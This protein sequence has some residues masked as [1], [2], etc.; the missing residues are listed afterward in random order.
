MQNPINSSTTRPKGIFTIQFFDN[1]TNTV[2]E[3]W[4][5]TVANLPSEGVITGSVIELINPSPCP[6]AINR[7]ANFK[8]S[9]TLANAL[10]L[11]SSIWIDTSADK[12]VFD[13]S[14]I[15]TLGCEIT[16]LPS[17]NS[18]VYPKCSIYELSDTVTRDFLKIDDFGAI[19]PGTRVS[20]M[21]RMMNKALPSDDTN[22]IVVHTCADNKGNSQGSKPECTYRVDQLSDAATFVITDTSCRA[23]IP[24]T[25]PPAYPSVSLSS[26]IAQASTNVSFLFVPWTA[27]NAS[28]STEL[29]QSS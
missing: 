22:T 27:I 29:P 23:T 26:Q 12:W 14:K 3:E 5:T 28:S 21:V 15:A 11:N 9:F 1:F 16:G 4:N 2:L 17:V 24:V 8:F 18:E 25:G 6:Y 19:G 10:P 13:R 20:V 7:A